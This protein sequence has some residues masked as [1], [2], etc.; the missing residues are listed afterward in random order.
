MV[1]FL[2]ALI[3]WFAVMALSSIGIEAS[4]SAHCGTDPTA[5][6]AEYREAVLLV[7][8]SDGKS[9]WVPARGDGCAQWM[10]IRDPRETPELLS[11]PLIYNS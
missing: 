3:E 10:P 4:G 9:G 2:I 11:P 6:P 7:N 1:E 5:R 8:G